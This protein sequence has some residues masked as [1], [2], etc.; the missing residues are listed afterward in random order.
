MGEA[1][2]IAPRW[3]RPPPAEPGG[4]FAVTFAAEADA[5]VDAAL[6]LN[7]YASGKGL[8]AGVTNRLEVV[9]EEL[10]AN[11]ILHAEARPG[12]RAVY[13]E[14]IADRTSA[15]LM[16]ADDGPEFDP[17]AAPAA[18][19]P[20]SLDEARIGGIGLR[21]VR[22][23]ADELVYDRVTPDAA[24]ALNRLTVKL[25]QTAPRAPNAP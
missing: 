16:V 8:D 23:M 9:F 17:T 22:R 4:A 5:L 21:L 15:T 6:A 13:A 10:V 24:P 20:V 18:P 11:I 14:A 1:R 25:R 12:A 7:L 19:A 3:L 2:Q